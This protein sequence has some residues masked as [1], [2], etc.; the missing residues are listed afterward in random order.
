MLAKRTQKLINELQPDAVF[1]QTNENWWKKAKLLQFVDS[2]EE[3]ENYQKEFEGFDQN[4]WNEFYW[5]TRKFI[6]LSRVWLYG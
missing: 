1:V 2:Q 6:F 4:E 5:S 3:F